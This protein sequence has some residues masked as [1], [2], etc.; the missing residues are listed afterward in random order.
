MPTKIDMDEVNRIYDA[1]L[2]HGSMEKTAAALD[3]PRYKVA[4][5]VYRAMGRC[6]CGRTPKEGY[7][8]CSVCI[9][10]SGKRTQERH[11]KRM[12]NGKCREC[13][14][15]L[16]EGSTSFCEKHLLKNRM[17]LRELRR[18]RVENGLCQACN[19]P[20]VDGRPYC[21]KHIEYA[22]QKGIE[23]RSRNSFGGLLF[24]VLE[25]DNS[26]CQIC[27]NSERRIEVHHIQGRKN[28]MENLV[29]LCVFC[30]KALTFLN[31][32]DKP[33]DV[34]AFFLAHPPIR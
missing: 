23:F 13:G 8:T 3:V 27:G 29:T 11:A 18:N 5:Y 6:Q 34:Y 31:C 9:E 2:V 19:E 32:C 21:P 33:D 25:R 12:A 22:F 20:A 7:A 24:D 4:H 17:K 16:A 15:P 14:T 28:T 26:T 10:S 30:H 1:Y